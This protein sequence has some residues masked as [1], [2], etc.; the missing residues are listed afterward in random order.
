VPFKLTA[1]GVP[2]ALSEKNREAGRRP[3]VLGVKVTCKVQDALTA[4][5][6]PHRLFTMAYSPSF[7]EML[8]MVSV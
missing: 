2:G 3:V 1:C 6:E 4:K 5:L 8:E 7:V